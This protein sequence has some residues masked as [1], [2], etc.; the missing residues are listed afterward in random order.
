LLNHET[1][2][3]LNIVNF[4]CSEVCQSTILLQ[5]T[6]LEKLEVVFFGV[7]ESPYRSASLLYHHSIAMET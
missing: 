4:H 3:L 2:Y 5:P 1:R 6:S 7:T